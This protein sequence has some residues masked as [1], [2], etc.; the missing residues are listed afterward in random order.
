MDIDI[1]SPYVVAIV[2]VACLHIQQTR[3]SISFDLQ[4]CLWP[5]NKC[6]SSVHSLYCTPPTL[7]AEKYLALQLL[8]T[9]LLYVHQL[10]VSWYFCHLMLCR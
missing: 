6:K 1:L 4:S 3:S 10:V 2:K 7:A 9:Q 8:N 5:P